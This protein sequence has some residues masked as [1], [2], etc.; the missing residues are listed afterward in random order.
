[1]L[2]ERFISLIFLVCFLLFAGH[3]VFPHQHIGEPEHV[4]H[5]DHGHG[6]HHHHGHHDHDT[7]PDPSDDDPVNIF[8]YFQHSGNTFITISHAQ[9]QLVKVQYEFF[10]TSY[11]H[12]GS[13]LK[14]DIPPDIPES[15]TP[16]YRNFIISSDSLRAPPVFLS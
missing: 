12:T 10:L 6:H 5:A 16:I 15:E 13:F 4:H 7:Q 8:S 2:K 11:L 14:P 1:M 3:D 9:T